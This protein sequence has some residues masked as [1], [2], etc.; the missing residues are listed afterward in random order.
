MG[1]CINHNLKG[2]QIVVGISNSGKLFWELIT[3]KLK[4]LV[5]KERKR[6]GNGTGITGKQSHSP[7][8]EGQE[9]SL[10]TVQGGWS[11]R[12]YCWR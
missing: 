8:R 2:I 6:E 3:K 1:L 9:E 7:A 10:P 12:L 4:G 11:P 5:E